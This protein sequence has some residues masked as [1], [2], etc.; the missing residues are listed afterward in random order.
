MKTW[1]YKVR[2]PN[3]E[4]RSAQIAYS[5]LILLLGIALGI[6][7][8]WL[9]N[10]GIS[11]HNCNIPLFTGFIVVFDESLCQICANQFDKKVVA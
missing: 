3:R 8:K 6:F 5:I 1:L 2:T 11:S 9:D 4:K 10:T 7:S